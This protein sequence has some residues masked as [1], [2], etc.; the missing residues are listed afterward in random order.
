VKK[1]SA[2]RRAP[3]LLLVA[4]SPLRLADPRMKLAL[5]LCLSLSVML[6]LQRLAV[7]V[8]FYALL[9]LWA[10]LLPA[11]VRRVW[12]L[13]WVL[14]VLFLVDW[15]LIS[16]ELAVAVTLRIVLLS[17]TFALFFATTTPDELRLALDW[18]RVPFRYAFSLSL[19]FQ[20]V[21]LLDEEW[22][23]IREAQKAR[24]A[25][26]P[27]SGWRNLAGQVRDL[28]A[29]AVPAIVMTTKRAWAMT[30]AAHAR[31]FD[32]PRRRLWRRLEMR[33]LDWL[34][35]AMTVAFSAA[36]VLWR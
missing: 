32:S 7:A 16:T 14:L 27:L 4:S 18:L 19:A 17:G 23:A 3:K 11:A 24:G 10:R 34:L 5:S 8:V 22:R 1:R 36:L 13:K 15:F 21:S 31:G 20:S 6:P 33:R 9:L 29:L 28:V 26:A 35:L 2:S 25:W 30:E 12:Q